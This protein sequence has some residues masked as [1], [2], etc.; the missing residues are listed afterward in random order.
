MKLLQALCPLV[1]LLACSTPSNASVLQDTCKSFAATRP[2]IGY[3]Y[4]VK[5]FQAEKGS[6]A[7]QVSRS[8]RRRIGVVG[9]GIAVHNL[10]G[11]WWAWRFRYIYTRATAK[12][13]L[14]NP[15]RVADSECSAGDAPPCRPFV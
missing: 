14:L 4:C 13:P 8:R 10:M 12:A 11:K 9:R 15:T 2:D 7:A 6:A 5:F 3:D 1:F